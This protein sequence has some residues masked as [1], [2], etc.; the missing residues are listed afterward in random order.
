MWRA[1]GGKRCR[2]ARHGWLFKKWLLQHPLQLRLVL[3]LLLLLPL[4]VLLRLLLLLA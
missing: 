4:L 3:L 2:Q 1:G